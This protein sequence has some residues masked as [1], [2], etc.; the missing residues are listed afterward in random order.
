MGY[1]IGGAQR[2]TAA[3]LVVAFLGMAP[4]A[5]AADDGESWFEDRTAA[6]GFDRKHTNR[7]FD[8]AY[9]AIMEGYTALGAAAAVG[10]FDGDGF[11]DLFLTDSAL[12]GKHLLYT[13]STPDLAANR[14]K[15]EVFH[16][17][18]RRRGAKPQKVGEGH[19]PAWL[20]DGLEYAFVTK[21]GITKQ[22][23]LDGP[24]TE[25]PVPAGGVAN[26]LWSPSGAHMAFTQGATVV[27]KAERWRS[28]NSRA[29]R[30]SVGRRASARG[31]GS[32]R[33]RRARR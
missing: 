11:D 21:K 17:V 19:S 16:L 10:D 7:S 18:L 20:R 2:W 23:L 33:A 8:N 6:A 9:A 29:L 30:G 32:P 28:C 15:T 12:D 14:S 26:L 3:A 5:A 4:A 22:P 13:V 24:V 31:G 1:C 27:R 25:I